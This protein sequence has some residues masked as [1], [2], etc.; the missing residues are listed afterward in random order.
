[1]GCSLLWVPPPPSRPLSLACF[2]SG[3]HPTRGCHQRLVLL[4]SPPSSPKFLLPSLQTLDM[5]GSKVFGQ[6]IYPL[7]NVDF[8]NLPSLTSLNVGALGTVRR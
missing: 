5:L 4:V 8:L 7:D 1:M 6:R 2:V 3:R